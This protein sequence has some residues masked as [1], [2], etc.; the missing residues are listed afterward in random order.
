MLAT[1]PKSATIHHSSV[2]LLPMP[3]EK[4]MLPLTKAALPSFLFIFPQLKK[5]SC[6]SGHIFE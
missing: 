3:T 1:L 4:K 5:K 2:Y 6:Q